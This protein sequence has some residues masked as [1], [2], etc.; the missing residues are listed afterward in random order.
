MDRTTTDYI[1]GDEQPELR[2]LMAQ[3]AVGDRISEHL[4]QLAGVAPGMRVL[5]LGCGAGDVS[6]LAA[7]LVGPSGTVVG[8]DASADALALAERR[9]QHLGLENVHFVQRD[10]RQL[11]A[12][13]LPVT[14]FDA[15][16]GRLILMY[17][18]DPAA[19]LRRCL[20]LLQPD[21]IVA[22][23]ELEIASASSVPHCE[24]FETAFARIRAAFAYREVDP[25]TGRRLGQI[26]RGAGLPSPAMHMEG[27]IE[28]GAEHLTC[29]AIAELTRSLLPVMQKAGIATAEAIDVDTLASRLR[30]EA[31]RSDASLAYSLLIGAWTRVPGAGAADL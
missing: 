25:R 1:L 14:S 11:T 9:A 18:P 29:D 15:L 12:A 16:V 4:F 27:C 28:S 23:Q 30:D 26:F 3:G 8:I 24:L 13:S 5:D 21:A 19:A 17:L 6:L 7:R 31:V 22:F 20:S 2:R 10:V